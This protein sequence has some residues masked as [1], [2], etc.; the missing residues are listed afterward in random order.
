[1][2]LDTARF[3]FAAWIE[4]HFPIVLEE[5]LSVDVARYE[6][7]PEAEAYVGS[8]TGFCLHHHREDW[9]FSAA[10][11]ENGKACPR[12]TEVLRAIPG[13]LVGGFSRLGPGTHI[14]PHCDFHSVGSIRCHLGLRAEPSA[15][16]RV[17]DETR[18][19]D[20]GRCMVFDGQ[21]LHEAVNEGST[22]RVVLLVDVDARLAERP[23]G[24][25]AHGNR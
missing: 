8:W 20:L 10:A 2:F 3:P 6:P 21:T 18:T 12:T 15:R 24:R 1:M 7:W 9:L 19:W 23:L 17:G 11:R 22:D 13:L 5:M 4:D 25:E 16:L 14:L